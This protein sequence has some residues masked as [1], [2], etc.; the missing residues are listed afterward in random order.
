MT[1]DAIMSAVL[2]L[3]PGILASKTYRFI[4]R[5]PQAKTDTYKAPEILLFAV[6]IYGVGKVCGTGSVWAHGQGLLLGVTAAQ[7]A[8]LPGRGKS[9]KNRC[10]VTHVWNQ[11]LIPTWYASFL[12]GDGRWWA[13][14][15]KGKDESIH[16]EIVEWPDDLEGGHYRVKAVSGG[17]DHVNDGGE[18]LIPAHT[19]ELL[20]ILPDPHDSALRRR[21][22]VC[23]HCRHSRKGAINAPAR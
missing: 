23:P 2:F 12:A 16:C 3:T 9:W 7:L 18:F 5:Q 6:I 20:E 17:R 10:F 21:P 4:T 1:P 13:I 15:R 22:T 11:S 14:E 8:L 19:V